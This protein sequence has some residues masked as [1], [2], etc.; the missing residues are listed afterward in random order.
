LFHLLLVGSRLHGSTC[1]DQF[2][3]RRRSVSMF[4]KHALEAGM[5]KASEGAMEFSLNPRVSCL[6]RLKDALSESFCPKCHSLRG[7]LLQSQEVY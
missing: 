1:I 3:S 6:L 4:L 5:Q 7:L 2:W